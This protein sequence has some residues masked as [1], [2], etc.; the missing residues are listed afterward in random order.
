MDIALEGHEQ[1]HKN[2]A[3]DQETVKSDLCDVKIP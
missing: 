2:T 3:H 1:A